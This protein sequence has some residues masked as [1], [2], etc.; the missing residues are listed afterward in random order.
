[1]LNLNDLFTSLNKAALCK[2]QDDIFGISEKPHFH[3]RCYEQADIDLITM[4]F[5]G[6]FNVSLLEG[7]ARVLFDLS[8]NAFDIFLHAWLSELPIEREIIAFGGKVAAAEKC[9]AAENVINN[10]L[11]A[12]TLTV[13]NAAA[14][15][16]HEVHRMMG[17]LR[18]TVEA[19]Q[20]IS[21]CGPD[22]FILPCLGEYF[23]S[24][25]GET[26]WSI[27]DEKRRLKLYRKTGEQA[28]IQILENDNLV[29][30]SINSEGKD[31]WEELWKHYHK[32]INNESRNNPNLQRQFMPKRYWKYLVEMNN[33]HN[34]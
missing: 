2:E 21:R 1:M 33:S 34:D 11:D 20:F 10:R 4:Y 29:L 24:R 6:E 18:F 19:D 28:K 7:S 3:T 17:F 13:L 30:N 12:D 31:E 14:K 22:H 8:S 32:T 5:T 23:T 9:S 16:Q 15:V 26:S 27:I 25:F